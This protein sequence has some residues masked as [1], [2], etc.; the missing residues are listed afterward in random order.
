MSRLSTSGASRGVARAERADI[1]PRWVVDLAESI[2]VQRAARRAYRVAGCVRYVHAP[3]HGD[4]C[5]T[6]LWSTRSV[7]IINV[8]CDDVTRER[9]RSA[10]PVCA[11]ASRSVRR[12]AVMRPS[13]PGRPRCSDR[14][15]SRARTSPG[16]PGPAQL[17]R[18]ALPARI[19][20]RP[21]SVRI[22]PIAGDHPLRVSALSSADLLAEPLH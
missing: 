2:T 22:G 1:P 15:I 5:R 8:V 20:P 4:G 14:D 11:A 12:G 13:A 17:A 10:G 21:T 7:F 18:S 3:L 9:G 6:R 16:A 19:G